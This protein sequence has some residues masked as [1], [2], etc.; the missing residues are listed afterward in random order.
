MARRRDLFILAISEEEGHYL[1]S[2]AARIR[3]ES[4]CGHTVCYS[5]FNCPEHCLVIVVAGFYIFENI[6]SA[7]LGTACRTPHKCYGLSSCYCLVRAEVC[8][9]NA[10][11]YTVLDCPEYRVVVVVGGFYKKAPQTDTRLRC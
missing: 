10:L 11:S 3:A 1:S 2:C 8:C 6:Y 5:V 9:V 4:G 7:D